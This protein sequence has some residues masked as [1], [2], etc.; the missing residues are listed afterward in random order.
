MTSGSGEPASAM[1][2]ISFRDHVNGDIKAQNQEMT[3]PRHQSAGLQRRLNRES[4]RSTLE[5]PK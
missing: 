5:G 4:H 3:A 1:R 2:R